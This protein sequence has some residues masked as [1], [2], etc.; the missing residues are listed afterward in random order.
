MTFSVNNKADSDQTIKAISLKENSS[1]FHQKKSF[2]MVILYAYN[3]YTVA[4][5]RYL[6]NTTLLKIESLKLTTIYLAHN[7]GLAGKSFDLGYLCWSHCC[8]YCQLVGG[9][10]RPT[11]L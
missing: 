3:Q 7:S 2:V 4:C 10:A 11:G 1:Q 6:A 8:S 9:S 5:I